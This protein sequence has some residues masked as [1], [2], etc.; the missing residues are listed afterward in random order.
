MCLSFRSPRFPIVASRIVMKRNE[1][2]TVI[3]AMRTNFRYLWSV[4]DQT[5]DKIA[6]CVIGST[7][8]HHNGST[9][10]HVIVGQPGDASLFVEPPQRS[11]EP[12]GSTTRDD[13]TTIKRKWR[14][15]Q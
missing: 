12:V 7:G 2:Y 8:I 10:W 15:G 4:G 5:G 13:H 11:Q 6:E 14:E 9:L 1:R 3:G